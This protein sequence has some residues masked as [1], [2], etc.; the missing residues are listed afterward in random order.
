VFLCSHYRA[1]HSTT[2]SDGDGPR[3]NLILIGPVSG[4]RSQQSGLFL[5]FQP[6][7]GHHAA[8]GTLQTDFLAVFVFSVAMA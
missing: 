8:A 1:L 6:D 2:I 4:I 7:L 5:L 3:P